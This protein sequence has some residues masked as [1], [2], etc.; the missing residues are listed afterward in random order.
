MV[1][2]C[3]GTNYRLPSYRWMLALIGAVE[4]GL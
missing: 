4:K 2:E 1:I 3:P